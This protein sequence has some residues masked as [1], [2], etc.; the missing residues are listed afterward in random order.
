MTSR[1]P[2]WCSKA[3]LWELNLHSG[4]S[5][6]WK[7]SKRKQST[8]ATVAYVAGALKKWVQERTGHSDLDTSW[9]EIITWNHQVIFQIKSN[10]MSPNSLFIN[11]LMINRE[12]IQNQTHMPNP[13][14][15][16]WF[17]TLAEHGTECEGA[18]FDSKNRSKTRYGWEGNQG[19]VVQAALD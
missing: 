13:R 16:W 18:V 6:E 1:R 5:R 12:M 19:F 17:W 11:I 3:V 4:W 2:H 8:S 7:R 10:V 15:W 14:L 9:I